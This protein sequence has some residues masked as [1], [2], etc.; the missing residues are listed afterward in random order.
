M[1][2]GMDGDEEGAINTVAVLQRLQREKASLAS[3]VEELHQELASQ[4][5]QLA[6]VP[7][8]ELEVLHY[9]ERAEALELEV[10]AL[11]TQNQHLGVLAHARRRAK[12]QVEAVAR[13][14]YVVASTAQRLALTAFVRWR[15]VA[16]AGLE[17]R[18][19]AESMRELSGGVQLSERK[20]ARLAQVEYDL[21]LLK[22]LLRQQAVQGRY[23]TAASKLSS[24]WQARRSSSLANAWF[25]WM[26]LP[27]ARV[28]Y[29]T[30]HLI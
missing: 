21:H 13:I 16:S 15:A 19:P 1:L 18:M 3:R 9:A 30:S 29:T 20:A 10:S 27:S 4:Q 8:L 24:L 28:L 14:R 17:Q 7:S 12:S 26:Q 5:T 2:D 6:V 22:R 23:A 25:M 11:Q